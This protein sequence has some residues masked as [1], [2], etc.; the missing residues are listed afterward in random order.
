MRAEKL[1][2]RVNRAGGSGDF[3]VNNMI[4]RV[5]NYTIVTV[6]PNKKE[7]QSWTPLRKLNEESTHVFS[8]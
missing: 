5:K 3:P 1:H 8:I 7:K 4:V 6:I 2:E